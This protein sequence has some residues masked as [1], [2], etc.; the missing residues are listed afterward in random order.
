MH[1]MLYV[2]VLVWV[3]PLTWIMSWVCWAALTVPLDYLKICS[4]VL[5][6]AA[7]T[8]CLCVSVWYQ[9]FGKVQI[10]DRD[11]HAPTGERERG[12]ELSESFSVNT[13]CS[14]FLNSPWW[15][16]LH[17]P[18]ECFSSSSLLFGLLYIYTVGVV[19]QSHR[20]SASL[21]WLL[22]LQQTLF[23]PESEK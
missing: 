15:S 22:Y 8:Y 9:L 21:I 10:S 12:V 19:L 7:N 18:A 23:N 16:W 4:A 3:W 20:V 11:S 13:C 14:F 2:I 5:F 1:W 6:T 17:F